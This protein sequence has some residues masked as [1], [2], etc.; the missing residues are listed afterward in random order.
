MWQRNRS[1]A[2]RFKATVD[3]PRRRA[4]RH[5]VDSLECD[6]GAVVD[7][8]SVGMRIASNKK[9]PLGVGQTG[10]IKITVPEG[11]LTITGRIV[12]QRRAG[13]RKWLIG[14]EFVNVKRS[15]TAALDSI[16]QFGFIGGSAIASSSSATDRSNQ[17]S[18]K[19]NKK[20]KKPKIRAS[21]DLPDYYHVLGLEAE[22]SADDIRNAFRILARQYHPDLNPDGEKRF[23]AIH[24]A[25]EVLKDPERR[26]SYDL[27]RAG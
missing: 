6:L 8:S 23:V 5:C 11:Q 4:K 21:M 24:E 27:Q 12:W 1:A 9:P 18:T 14:V 22:A 15:I 25:Y 26:R 10:R 13:L 7:L 17:S 16:A 3:D 2:W 20:K 19:A